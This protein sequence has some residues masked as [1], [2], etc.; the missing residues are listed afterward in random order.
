MRIIIL[1][2]I[3]AILPAITPSKKP[4]LRSPVITYV[5]ALYDIGRGQMYAFSR[6]FEFYLSLFDELLHTRNNIIVYG[7][8]SLRDFVYAHRPPPY[9]N[10]VFVEQSI[11]D[12]LEKWW[13]GRPLE[14]LQ[15][16]VMEHSD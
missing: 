14:K 7:D 16:K 15:A 9:S 6:P 3:A 2:I 1:L 5:T 10:I 12:I 4:R 13:F 8:R 11:D